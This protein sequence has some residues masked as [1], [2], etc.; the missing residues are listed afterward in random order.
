M[1]AAL[2]ILLLMLVPLRAGAERYA[3]LVGNNAGHGIDVPLRYAETDA[4]RVA[5]TLVE[6]GGF[7]TARVTVL[8]SPNVAQVEETFA[9]VGRA[10]ERAHDG[11]AMVFFYYS[12]HADGASLHLSP[13]CR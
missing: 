6:L 13:H 8:R 4:D 11:N 10:I 3:I 2:W 9:S 7:A 1:R 5:S 12:G